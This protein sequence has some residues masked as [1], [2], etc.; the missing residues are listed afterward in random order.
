MKWNFLNPPFSA[1][2]NF[3]FF[4]MGDTMLI[5]SLTFK[6][7]VGLSFKGFVSELTHLC[8]EGDDTMFILS[9]T[10]K[11]QVRLSFKGFVSE[12]T[13]VDFRC[14]RLLLFESLKI[15]L[16]VTFYSDLSTSL[17]SLLWRCCYI[18]TKI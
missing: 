2:S 15:A 7:E 14:F 6:F 10:F 12:L 1:F 4:V 9:L 11:F 3:S 17:W 16:G 18:T 8:K 5:L 13:K